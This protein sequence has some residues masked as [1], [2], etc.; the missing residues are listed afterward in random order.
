MNLVQLKHRVRKVIKSSNTP[1]QLEVARNYSLLAL[2]QIRRKLHDT[3]DVETAK[4]KFTYYEVYFEEEY[5]DQKEKV[6]AHLVD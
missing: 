5:F 4:K 2:K 6:Y 1:L 3:L